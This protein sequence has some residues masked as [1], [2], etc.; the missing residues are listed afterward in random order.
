VLTPGQVA[1]LRTRQVLIINN[2]M[3]PAITRARMAYQRWDLRAER[4][5]HRRSVQAFARRI[6]ALEDRTGAWL[7]GQKA[8]LRDQAAATVERAAAAQR[9]VT[10]PAV[11]RLAAGL[12][13]LDAY[14]P[15]RELIARLRLNGAMR[16]A[17]TALAAR[18][19][20]KTAA[21]AVG[22]EVDDV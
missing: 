15:A 10:A 7:L 14:D 21:P 4:F 9:R 6:N 19:A 1:E 11:R 18:A 5:H 3:P 17:S 8:W 12:V 20:E 2:G 22:R 13:W 16:R